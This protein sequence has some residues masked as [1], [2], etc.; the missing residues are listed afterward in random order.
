[1]LTVRNDLHIV[2]EL[3]A[4]GSG[5]KCLCFTQA[6]ASKWCLMTC[7]IVCTIDD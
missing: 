5:A 2:I 3:V 1:M 4:A 7:T 6:R